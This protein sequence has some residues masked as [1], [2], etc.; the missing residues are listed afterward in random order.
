MRKKNYCE[1]RDI[2]GIMIDGGIVSCEDE[3]PNGAR[4]Y[5]YSSSFDNHLS[6]CYLP[7]DNGAAGLNRKAE[8][9]LELASSNKWY[10]LK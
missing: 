10:A 1:F 3:L 5:Y 4:K 2:F 9:S 6:F 8:F 7:I